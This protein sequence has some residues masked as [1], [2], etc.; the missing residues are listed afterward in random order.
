MAI[1]LA[2]VDVP[3]SRLGRWI[4]F[5]RTSKSAVADSVYAGVVYRHARS[6][7]VRTKTL[8][9]KLL[10]CPCLPSQALLFV[11]WMVQTNVVEE[12][13]CLKNNLR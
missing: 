3:R 11:G 2:L 8:D 4:H 13:R 1:D 12:G 9:V 6:P 5:A 10:S 7:R